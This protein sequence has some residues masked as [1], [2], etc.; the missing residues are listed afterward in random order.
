MNP[1]DVLADRFEVERLAATGGMGD[2]YRARD[3]TSGETVGLKVLH[4]PGA[5][6]AARFAREAQ[7]LAE[8]RH[9]GI[10]RY[11]AHRQTPTRQLYLAMEWLEGADLAR[12]LTRGGLSVEDSVSMARAAA[13]ALGAAHDR[14]IVHR[15]VKPSNLFLPNT[16]VGSGFSGVKLLDFGIARLADATVTLTGVTFGTPGYM[17]PEQAKGDRNLD[18][19]ADIFA[20]G[21]VLFECLTG[22][23]AF[24]GEHVMAILAKIVLAD[25][26]RVRELRPEVPRALDGLVA[27][28]LA[29]LPGDRPR[30]GREVAAEMASLGPLVGAPVSVSMPPESSLTPG[31]Q[32]L[33]C[34]VLAG[35]QGV[36]PT[37]SVLAVHDD[38]TGR[39]GTSATPLP[40][41]LGTGGRT[42]P[43][44]TA[45][46]DSLRASVD[47]CD[48]HIEILADGSVIATLTGGKS[49]TDQAAQAARCALALRGHMPDVPV[50]IATGRGVLAGR[51]PVGEAIDR[52]VL[53]LR[54]D[55]TVEDH[56][57]Q[58]R[59]EP[60]PR[61]QP[62]PRIRI[63]D[64]TAG[65]LDLRFD[66][67]GDSGGLYLRGER[68]TPETARTLLGKETPCVGRERELLTL[69]ALFA[70]C[71]DEGVARAALITAPAG[72]GKSR[73]ASELC[74][75]IRE[76]DERVEIW[77]GR[78][79]PLSAG[80]PFGMI[81]SAVRH[82]AGVRAGEPLA[83]R[84]KK[85][86][87][88]VARNLSGREGAR[89][90]E[91]LGELV[92]VPFPD[93]DS[94]QLRAARQDAMLMGDQIR[95]AF[96]DFLAIECATAPVV[97]LLEDLHWGDLPSVKLV[98]AALR[99]LK[100]QPLMVLALARPE[101]HELFP[102]LWDDRRVQGVRLATLTR[103]AGERLVRHV[104]GDRATPEVVQKLCDHAD[105]NAFYLEELIR[106]VAE[107]RDRALPPTVLAM[108]HAR[109]EGL[110]AEA[111]W[112]L[113]A[114]SVFGQD[115]W[116][117]GV[118]TLLGGV[119]T[120]IQLDRCLQSLIEQE[121]VD[122]R[123]TSGRFP[124]EIEY[125]FRHALVREA[126]YAML[127]DDDRVLGH[128]L[129]GTWLEK[130]GET[131]A[132]I[133][134]EHFD[135]GGE[136]ARAVSWYRRAAAQALEGN[137]L[138]AAVKRVERGIALHHAAASPSGSRAPTSPSHA[139]DMAALSA[140]N[141]ELAAAAA[142][143]GSGGVVARDPGGAGS[144]GGRGDASSQ[145]SRPKKDRARAE[146]GALLLLGAE[147]HRWRGEHGE[148]QARAIEALEVIPRGSTRWYTAVGEVALATVRLGNYD[149]LLALV[150]DLTAPAAD[151]ASS[152]RHVVTLGRTA[153][154]L[155]YGGRY[156]EAERDIALID[157]LEKTIAGVDPAAQAV[158]HR[159]R[160]T[161]A[162]G[163]GDPGA[164][165]SGIEAAAACFE[166]AGD[167]RNA[168]NARVNVGHANMELGAYG[169]AETALRE[170]M[171][172]AARMG[173]PAVAALAKH[174]L[175]LALARRGSLDLGEAIEREAMY[176]F[177]EQGDR[178][179]EGGSR[180]YLALILALADKPA[181]AER[182]A[183]VAEEMVASIFG[184]RAYALGVLAV[185]RIARGGDALTPARK[186][187]ELLE[188]IGG[189]E[190]G[191][192][193]IRLAHA[194]ALAASEHTEAAA[195]AIRA[196][197]DRLE[198]RAAKI[199]DPSHRASF[200]ERVPDNA[201][202]L[203]LFRAWCGA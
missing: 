57:P 203:E 52:A 194:E 38:A 187:I 99:V 96:E 88:R 119:E 49:A 32:K 74:K 189:V 18:S 133:L 190:E 131:E 130:A 8:L 47:L 34:V 50:V 42:P 121:V 76:R 10:V 16:G 124:E 95:R 14:G 172:T 184:L 45:T 161:R 66:V 143:L 92:G 141:R 67:G 175:G 28:M 78:G 120:G 23:A 173:L 138:A 30:D 102:K 63:D 62:G 13:E 64:V 166:Q 9:P 140:A 109:L 199:A 69:E 116:K 159:V 115:F 91:F 144:T 100:N 37:T 113:R 26:P 101:V 93:G 24:P 164:Y 185:V 158:I 202:T 162:V 146:L 20:L 29:K 142:G 152:R 181:E 147:A 55:E 54:A 127:T 171:A 129:A 157:R 98:D 201:R 89:I 122:L 6:Y 182:E 31:E 123:S 44:G 160:A 139:A 111:R 79:D 137:D 73:V 90:T 149:R 60:P 53:L 4:G 84:Q 128:K 94:V 180:I 80:S 68:E 154:A 25:A 11:I 85:L 197:R 135:R 195:S 19:T 39:L 17:A 163:T 170:A 103:K 51:L 156:T 58:S 134:A 33:L 71:V 22:R 46:L 65:L 179:L 178:R 169:R 106:A 168:C 72:I 125:R 153:V 7:L 81:A 41:R 86:A 75:K 200:R 3:R 183:L 56:S 193:L 107:G 132:I 48:A 1:G 108:V 191:E 82:T 167:L 12:Q 186:A 70:D 176:A 21:C 155:L 40:A 148:A 27:R 174:N 136:P 145:A 118:S 177:R 110:G 43:L 196:A 87:A 112:V 192:S 114:S 188:E 198:A 35:A 5:R 59:G 117:D 77:I 165:L 126:A 15:D 97:L 61:S 104:L 151:A 105:G 150:D 83:V 2:V 36:Q